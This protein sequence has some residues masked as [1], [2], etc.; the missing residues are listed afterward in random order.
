[1]NWG[2]WFSEYNGNYRSIKAGILYVCS[3][4]NTEKWTTKLTL[5]NRDY[6]QMTLLDYFYQ[7]CNTARFSAETPYFQ[8]GMSCK[9]HYEVA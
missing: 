8:N 1:M 2:P 7:R 3:I 5:V 4:S 6:R 9:R